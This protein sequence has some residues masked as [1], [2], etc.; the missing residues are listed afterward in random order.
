MEILPEANYS[1]LFNS[2][3]SGIDPYKIASGEQYVDPELF[4]LYLT[5]SMTNMDRILTQDNS[6]TSTDNS[7][8]FPIT[9]FTYNSMQQNSPS[10]VS[11]SY[12]IY[13]QM[14]AKSNLIGKSVE[15]KDPETGSILTGKVS[16]ITVE[17]GK[18]EVLVNG[19]KIPPENLISVKE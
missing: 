4:K 13:E 14:I 19:K 3:S 12:S 16:G 17:S 5:T 6:D 18:L 15:A 1:A 2:Q 8:D 9:D 10:S 7:T 11:P